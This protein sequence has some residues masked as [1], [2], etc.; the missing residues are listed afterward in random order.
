[1]E[2]NAPRGMFHIGKI[3]FRVLFTFSDTP[4]TI[5]TNLYNCSSFSRAEPERAF[6]KGACLTSLSAFI[7]C[8]LT[9]AVLLYALIHSM[10]RTALQ[11][12]LL[13]H[14]FE[15]TEVLKH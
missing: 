2:K 10:L 12:L 3:V 14:I 11:C 6:G 4:G 15:N 5:L 8:F 1:M 13:P 7:A 9:M